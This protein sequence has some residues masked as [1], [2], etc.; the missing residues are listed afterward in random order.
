MGS[1]D[2]QMALLQQRSLY[3]SMASSLQR[4]QKKLLGKPVVVGA[5]PLLVQR[6]Y[7]LATLHTERTP[8]SLQ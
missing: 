4:V 7:T 1:H 5:L 2:G 3:E 6:H 8:S